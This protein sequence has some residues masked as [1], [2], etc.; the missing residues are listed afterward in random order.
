MSRAGDCAGQTV[1]VAR[2]AGRA[3]LALAAEK[4]RSPRRGRLAIAAGRVMTVVLLPMVVLI[5]GCPK[6]GTPG[7]EPVK[8]QVLQPGERIIAVNVVVE[9]AQVVQLHPNFASTI[10]SVPVARGDAVTKDQI[11]IELDTELLQAELGKAEA[12]RNKLQVLIGK[13]R[14]EDRAVDAQVLEAN[15]RSADS[16][17][18]RLRL[19]IRRAVIRSPIDGVVEE[20]HAEVGQYVQAGESLIRI[21]STDKLMAVGAAPAETARLIRVGQSATVTPISGSWA[22]V[23]EAV[24][25]DV[26]LLAMEDPLF[27]ENLKVTLRLPE[28]CSLKPGMMAKALIKVSAPREP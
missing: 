9:S 6:A 4:R 18:N 7:D 27:A 13:A 24:V 28:G 12:E 1:W 17:V 20:R 11:L 22:Q 19:Y 3:G 8:I 10:R 25:D 21:V 15:L 14:A 2:Y 23:I 26:G 5:A 16:E